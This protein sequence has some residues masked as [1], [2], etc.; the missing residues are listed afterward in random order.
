MMTMPPPENRQLNETGKLSFLH[1]LS[2]EVHLNTPG[3]DEKAKNYRMKFPECRDDLVKDIY[4]ELNELAF[5]KKL[6]EML[7]ILWFSDKNR[8]TC[9]GSCTC[10]TT[11]FHD[12]K[13]T[14]TISLNSARVSFVEL[15]FIFLQSEVF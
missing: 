2:C 14:A 4:R 11:A 9:S 13:R 10:V 7:P 3:I 5:D 6:P 8:A 12:T 15:F 1:S